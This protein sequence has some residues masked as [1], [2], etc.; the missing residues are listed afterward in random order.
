M[1]DRQ[2]RE[3]RAPLP[4][5]TAS[6]QNQ[7]DAVEA[8]MQYEEPGQEREEDLRRSLHCL[9]EWVCELLTRNQELRMSLLASASN[10]QPGEADQ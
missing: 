7:T 5:C 9:Q 1:C 6:T 4:G 10:H 3:S 8:K 2:H